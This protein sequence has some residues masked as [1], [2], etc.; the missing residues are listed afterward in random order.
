MG[1]ACSAEYF[2]RFIKERRHKGRALV[3]DQFRASAMLCEDLGGI[4]FGARLC[5]LVGD[6]KC[7]HVLRKMV[8]K[9]QNVPVSARGQGV[10]KR[11]IHGCGLERSYCFLDL[12]M[13][14]F[15]HPVL[16]TF[17]TGIASLNTF[18]DILAHARP[19]EAEFDLEPRPFDSKMGHEN[20]VVIFSYYVVYH[21]FRFE[22]L[23]LVVGSASIY[24]TLVI[25]E[26]L[27]LTRLCTRI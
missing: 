15:K 24:D 8:N 21:S 11:N 27:A 7:F 18:F 16:T 5:W 3:S 26:I 14:S 20:G 1:G 23:L 4:N 25:Q 19:P 22:Q 13:W 10:T 12:S 2:T 6:R 17:I 9:V